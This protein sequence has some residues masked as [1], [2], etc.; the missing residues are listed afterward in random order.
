VGSIA[1]VRN[2]SHWLVIVGRLDDMTR[3]E[4]APADLYHKLAFML[5]ISYAQYLFFVFCVVN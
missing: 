2:R 4:M 1:I 3:D 5:T